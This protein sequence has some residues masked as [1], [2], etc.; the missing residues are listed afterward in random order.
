[1]SSLL[2]GSKPLVAKANAIAHRSREAASSRRAIFVQETLT[3]CLMAID[4]KIMSAAELGLFQVS[5][6]LH[7]AVR[8]LVQEA[9]K[10]PDKITEAFVDVPRNAPLNEK[11]FQIIVDALSKFLTKERFTYTCDDGVFTVSW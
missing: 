10:Y 6:N 8:E 1:M 2:F 4:T 5:Y 9:N 11:E 3:T 7:C